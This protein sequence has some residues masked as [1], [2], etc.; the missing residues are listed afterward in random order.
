MY[1]LIWFLCESL[2]FHIIILKVS[3]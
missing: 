2:I 3:Y 1:L